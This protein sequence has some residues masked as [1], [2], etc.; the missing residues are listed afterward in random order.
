M[1][2]LL[3]HLAFTPSKS[4]QLQ[5]PSG[6]ASKNDEVPGLLETHGK[7]SSFCFLQNIKKEEF[8]F[9]SKKKCMQESLKLSF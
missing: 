9:N 3:W 7:F 2:P 1:A 8:Q 6:L 5:R 4:W